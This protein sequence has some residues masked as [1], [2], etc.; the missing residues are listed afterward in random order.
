MKDV[1]L[2]VIINSLLIILAVMLSVTTLA[3]FVNITINNYTFILELFISFLIIYKIYNK[4]LNNKKSLL[5]NL[6][7]ITLIIL[8]VSMFSMN[9]YDLTWDGN[10]YHKNLIGLLKGG[11]NPLYNNTI[12][13]EWMIH[14]ANSYEILAAIF[15]AT[16]NNIEAGK[17]IDILLSIVLFYNIYKFSYD[18]SKSKIKA[19]LFSIPITF[20]P[21]LLSQFSA[22]YLDDIVAITLYYVLL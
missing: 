1:N 2:K 4:D 18:L 21:F 10:T 14:Y 22:Y 15:Y 7:I 8:I 6:T 11:L 19:I 13:D 3:Y 5:I 20:S 17:A 16:F 9:F 12:G